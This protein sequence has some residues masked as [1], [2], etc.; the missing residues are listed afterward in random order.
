MR[1]PA[2]LRG[3]GR[4][5]SMFAAAGVL[6]VGLAACSSDD[7]EAAGTPFTQALSKD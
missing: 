3:H 7:E 2:A 4:R 5:L 6:A 1:F